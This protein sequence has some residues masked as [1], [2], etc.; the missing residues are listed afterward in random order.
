MTEL[1]ELLDPE[2]PP[3]IPAFPCSTHKCNVVMKVFMAGILPPCVP[4]NFQS[5]LYL[6][7]ERTKE[8]RLVN[9]QKPF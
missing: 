1:S 4:F 3:K 2:D 8:S 9:K 7:P 6:S 5:I